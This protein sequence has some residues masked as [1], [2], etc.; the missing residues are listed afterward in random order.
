MEHHMHDTQ[1]APRPMDTEWSL[2]AEQASRLAVIAV[3]ADLEYWASTAS[4]DGRLALTDL[5]DVLAM[6]R[7]ASTPEP[8]WS[9]LN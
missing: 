2:T 5:V 8:Y 7:Q 9:D 4:V 6:V 3:T 1:L